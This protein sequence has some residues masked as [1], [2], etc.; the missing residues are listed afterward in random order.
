M[1]LGVTHGFA[2]ELTVT[3]CSAPAAV[4]AHAVH[5]LRVGMQAMHRMFAKE[6]APSSQWTCHKGCGTKDDVRMLAIM[7]RMV[8]E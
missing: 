6:L 2:K 7:L 4:R 5:V 1:G 8:Q 3:H